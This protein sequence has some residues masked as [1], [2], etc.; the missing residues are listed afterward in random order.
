MARQS[1]SLSQ[2]APLKA[3]GNLHDTAY[4]NFLMRFQFNFE[5]NL[6]AYGPVLYDT[7]ATDLFDLYL[8]LLPTEQEKAHCNC[9]TCRRFINTFG[10]LAFMKED[11]T[12]VSAFWNTPYIPDVYA[13]SIPMMNSIV[14]RSNVTG[15][16]KSSELSWGT[17]TTGK[18][19][20]FGIRPPQ[21]IIHTDRLHTAQAA[22]AA[23]KQEFDLL[24]RTLAEYSPNTVTHA[25]TLLETDA[26]YRSEKVRGPVAWFSE[27]QARHRKAGKSKKDNLVWR[28]VATA[29]V[30]FSHLKSGMAGTLLDDLQGGLPYETAAKRFAAKMHPLQYQRPQAAPKAGNIARGEEIIEKLGLKRSLKRR[31]ARLDEIRTLWRPNSVA[32]KTVKAGVF[33]HL[34]PGVGGAKMIDAPA[35]RVTWEKFQRVYLPQAT[36]IQY[37][38]QPK[39]NFCGLLTA[40]YS[41]APPILQWDL[42]GN[43]NPFSWYVWN[44]GATASSFGLGT[45]TW[46]TVAGISLKPSMW[47]GDNGHQGRGIVLILKNARET[48]NAGN[49][50]FP[51]ILRSELRE[52]RATIEKYSQNE[53]LTG[54]D[55]GACGLLLDQHA[56]AW[57]TPIRAKIN[58]VWVKFTLERWD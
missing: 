56:T 37:F 33:G 42:D 2:T 7:D 31:F 18:W 22:S 23:L 29:P 40:T 24:K 35:Q 48:R 6:K 10:R 44:G 41:L 34:K 13:K 28:A 55:K 46:E 25:L 14:T 4:R 36:E 11:G 26:L 8:E 16:F 5:S 17:P 52:I 51:E 30:G 21:S 49:A 3:D 47:T 58:G 20:H 45:G 39:D 57:N 50:L 9:N 19:V 54:M 1:L 15:V 43:R 53:K 32:E 27:L 12:L 38:V